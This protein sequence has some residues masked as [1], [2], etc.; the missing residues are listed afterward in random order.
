MIG[1]EYYT[2]ELSKPSSRYSAQIVKDD[3]GT[4]IFKL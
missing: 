1:N 2:N 3:Y 4:V